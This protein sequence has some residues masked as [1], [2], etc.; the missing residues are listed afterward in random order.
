MKILEIERKKRKKVGSKRG[1]Q[2]GKDERRK[3]IFFYKMKILKM[4][5]RKDRRNEKKI[6]EL[7]QE[8]IKG[9]IC[10]KYK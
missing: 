4:I 7:F 3:K 6:Q 1:G 2:E 8:E 10:L 5:Q 9:V